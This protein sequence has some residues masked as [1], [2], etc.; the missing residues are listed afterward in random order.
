MFQ[1]KNSNEPHVHVS[2]NY[3][4]PHGPYIQVSW[5]NEAWHHYIYPVVTTLAIPTL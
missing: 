5:G 1:F 2:F 3:G 4:K